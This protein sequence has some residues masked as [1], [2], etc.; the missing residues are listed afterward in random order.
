M[1]RSVLGHQGTKGNKKKAKNLKKRD[2]R[3]TR[4]TKN[5]TW[6][7]KNYS[8]KIDE[9]LDSKKILTIIERMPQ[10][11]HMGKSS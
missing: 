8:P 4:N 10:N 5:G 1:F 3:N 6:S 7:I 2:R 11:K 9:R